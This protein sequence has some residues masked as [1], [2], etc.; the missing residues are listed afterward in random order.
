VLLDVLVLEKTLYEI[1]YELNHRPDWVDIPLRGL[2]QEL[3]NH[4]HE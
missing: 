2:L 3:G 1:N 4:P